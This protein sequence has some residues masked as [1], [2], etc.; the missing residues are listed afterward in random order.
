MAERSAEDVLAGILRVSVGG[1]SKALPTLSIRATREWKAGL[2]EG[3]FS[4]PE[5]DRDWTPEAV[6][7]FAD[8]TFGELLDIITSYDR[9]AALGGREWLE[10]NADPEQLYIAAGQISEVAFPFAHNPRVVLAALL[11]RSVVASKPQSSTNGHSPSG[12]S[13]RRRSRSVSTAPR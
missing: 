8:L 5:D 12:A 6:A 3:L 7:Q 9:T 1:Q 2:A 10:D 11:A 4:A 13:T